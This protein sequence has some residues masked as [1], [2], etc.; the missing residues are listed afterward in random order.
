MSN[1]LNLFVNTLSATTIEVTQK[2]LDIIE[3]SYKAWQSFGEM[4]FQMRILVVI[5]FLDALLIWRCSQ[6]L[7]DKPKPLIISETKVKSCLFRRSSTI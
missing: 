1:L 4:P 2:V 5:L 7:L 6:R 3:Y